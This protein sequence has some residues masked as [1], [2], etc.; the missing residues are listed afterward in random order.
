MDLFRQLGECCGGFISA[1]DGASLSSI[2]WKI[3]GGSLIPDEI[4]IC[5]GSEVFPV[6][7]EA[8]SLSPLSGHGDKLS[9][10]SDWRAKGK[11][12]RVGSPRTPPGSTP[13]FLPPEVRVSNPPAID[14]T[15][16]WTEKVDGS[17]RS[18]VCKFPSA[19]RASSSPMNVV[20]LS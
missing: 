9:F 2:R 16:F 12:F 18:A 10:F 5:H 1:E 11:G 3:K 17:V 6:R 14:T 15:D 20:H 4:L 13:E 8:E 7:L 19:R